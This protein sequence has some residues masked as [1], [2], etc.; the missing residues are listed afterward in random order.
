MTFEKSENSG[1]NEKLRQ[2]LA[3]ALTPAVGPTRARRLVEHC[4]G[5]AQVFRASLTELE[6]AGLQ[7]VSAQA[8][9]TGKSIELAQEEMVRAAAAGAQILPLDDPAYPALLRQIYDPPVVL[10]VKGDAAVLSLAGIAIVGTRH[11]TPYGTGM[12]ERLAA[13]LAVRGLAIISGLARGV[14]A[15]A[16]RGAVAARGKTV[17]VFGTGVDQV[18]PRENTKLADSILVTGGAVIS[19]FPMASF[20]APQNFP[21]RN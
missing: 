6:A 3:L 1:D 11:P 16:H 13:D 12:A 20:P 10:Y 19:E 5:I 15:A 4:G 21:I 17:A 8:L 2:W 18:Y 9:A 7:A 14:D